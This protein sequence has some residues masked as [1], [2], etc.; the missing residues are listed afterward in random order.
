MTQA[1]LSFKAAVIQLVS[2]PK[3]EENLSIVSALVEDAHREGAAVVALPE[4]FAIMGLSDQ[5]KV[6][7]REALD[8]GP[9]QA[10][11]S[12]LAKKYSLYIVGGTLPLVSQD[13]NKVRN[14][15]LV[16][17]PNGERIGRYDKIHLFGFHRGDESYEES[18]TIEPGHDVV[19]LDTPL[20][21]WG[22]SVC[23]DLRF[24][25]LY[26][27]MAR[28]DL[29]FVPAA[30]TETTG[31]AHW[32]VLLRARAIENLAYVLAPGQGGRHPSGRETYGSSMII[33]PWGNILKRLN[34]GPGVLVAEIDPGLIERHRASLPALNHMTLST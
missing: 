16:Y 17:A 31:R 1:S 19:A 15:T 21:R 34:K 26:R 28:P 12:A 9:I 25:E 7:V 3:V 14:T 30:F 20:G 5:D 18:L 33:D 6:A 2:G 10:C 4:Y 29:I 22:L 13:P 24:P 11:L 32:E 23:Y 8:E 27:K